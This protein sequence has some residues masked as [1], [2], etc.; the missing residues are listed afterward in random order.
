[1]EAPTQTD[2]KSLA[3]LKNFIGEAVLVL[4]LYLFFYLPGL[5]VNILYYMEARRIGRLAGHTPPG[6][7]CLLVLLI[8]G[9]L[10]LA[11]TL[12]FASFILPELMNNIDEMVRQFR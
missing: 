4:F 2:E 7:G 6:Q 3:R 10:T 8:W 1:M 11:G 12:F 9:V 5:I